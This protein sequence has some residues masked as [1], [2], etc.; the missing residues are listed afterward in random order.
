MV[1]SWW[2]GPCFVLVLALVSPAFAGEVLTNDA[3]VAMV[4][5]GLAEEVIVG[6]VLISGAKYDLSADGLLKLKSDGVSDAIVRAMIEASAPPSSAKTA[7]AI[8][9]GTQAAIALYRQGKG[10][11]AVVAFD[12]LLMDRPNDDALRI[13]KARALLEQ[14]RAL[15]DVN[16]SGFK[17]LVVDAYRILH[18]MGRAHAQDPDWNFAMA[19]AFWL[20]ERPTWAGRAA[21]KALEYRPDFA[22]AQIVLGDLSYDSER[23]A[24]NAPPTDPRRETARRFA[25]E[26]T[27]KEYE[28]V[29]AIRDVPATVRAEVLYKIGLVAGELEGK[30]ALAR[31]SWERAVA[32]DPT[33][34]YGALAQ[35]K[36]RAV[37]GK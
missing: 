1:R 37:G 23:D 4:K 12:K 6:K 30:A 11:E 9:K 28:K 13:W 15:K 33:C 32:A 18:P 16:T 8:A 3:V 31:E 22:E 19:Q 36:L 2:I 10:A 20:N 5:S 17:P 34:R 14:A 26:S 25:G 7:D 29:L 27:R 35:Q 24:I 21:G